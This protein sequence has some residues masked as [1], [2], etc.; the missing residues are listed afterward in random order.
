MKTKEKSKKGGKSSGGLSVQSFGGLSKKRYTKGQGVPRITLKQGDTRT[1][2]FAAPISDEDQWKEI[3]QHQFQD[4]GKWNYVPCLG[5]NCPLCE[6]EDNEVR[7]THYRFFTNAYDF[8]EKQWAVLEG[9][10]DLSGR[11]ARKFERLEK[12][13][14]GSFLKRTFDISKMA[15]TPVSYDVEMGDDDPVKLDPKKLVDLKAYLHDQAVRYFGEDMPT[16]KSKGKSALDD[17]DDDA[18]EDEYDEDDLEEMSPKE[19]KAVAK[20]LGIKLI[21]PKTDEKRSKA[22]LIKLIL[23]K[24]G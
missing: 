24:Q 15:T 12:K 20:G 3:E 11:I 13:K 6:D 19:V 22:T 8:K 7:K 5:K 2:Q 23:K 10:K 1:V 9:P 4:N 18:D 17:D 21:N 14:V 16:S